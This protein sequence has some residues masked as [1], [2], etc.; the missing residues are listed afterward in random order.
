M[1][2][3][4][5][6]GFEAIKKL[7]QVLQNTSL[8]NNDNSDICV[9]LFELLSG[10]SEIIDPRQLILNIAT[11]RFEDEKWDQMSDII[12]SA[13]EIYGD[14]PIT[15]DMFTTILNS[16]N[17]LTDI[18]KNVSSDVSTLTRF[19]IILFSQK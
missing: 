5:N 11:T 14:R 18:D 16:K 1:E 10:G 9:V 4:P 13:I 19:F 17:I 8:T 6:L 12:I 15:L 7:R 3:I 2:S